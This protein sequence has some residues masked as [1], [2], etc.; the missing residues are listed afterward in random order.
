VI[1][2]DLVRSKSVNAQK[3]IKNEDKVKKCLQNAAL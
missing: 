1:Y 3:K 2:D